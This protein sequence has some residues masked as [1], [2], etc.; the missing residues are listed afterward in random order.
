MTLKQ[1]VDCETIRILSND[2]EDFGKIL[3]QH[4]AIAES[5]QA[6]NFISNVGQQNFEGEKQITKI[7]TD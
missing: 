3:Q 2:V 4:C 6:F 7:N 5:A 1:I